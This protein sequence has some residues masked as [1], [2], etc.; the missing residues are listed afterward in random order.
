MYVHRTYNGQ[1]IPQYTCSQYGKYPIGTL[2]QT[3]HRINANVVMTLIADMLKL[4]RSIP[5]PTGPSLSR[6]YRRR[7]PQQTTDIN[8]KKEAACNGAEAGRELERLI[9]KI[10][11]D[12][13]LGKLPDAR[14]AALDAQYA[15]EQNELSS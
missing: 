1:R 2:C 15:K 6:P 10:Y 3:Q 12:N 9:C 14:Y 4:S 8:K 11:E 13:A 5:R 7:R